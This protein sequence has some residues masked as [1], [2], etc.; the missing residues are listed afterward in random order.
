M[1]LAAA[2]QQLGRTEE[3]KAAMQE[4][5]RLRPGTTALNVAPPMKNTSPVFVQAADRMIKLM[6]AAGLPER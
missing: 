3:A 5:L 6:I 4:G 1:N 2:Y